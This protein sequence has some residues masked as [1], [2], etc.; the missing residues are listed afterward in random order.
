M[1]VL[2]ITTIEAHSLVKHA[3]VIREAKIVYLLPICEVQLVKKL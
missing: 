3:I 1:K 2:C